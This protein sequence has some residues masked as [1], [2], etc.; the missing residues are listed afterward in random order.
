MN[1]FFALVHCDIVLNIIEA[2]T[3]SK[4]RKTY[5]K[6]VK[7]NQKK[8][9]KTNENIKK[10]RNRTQVIESSKHITQYSFLKVINWLSY[11]EL[12]E[13]GTFMDHYQSTMNNV[14]V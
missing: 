3:K 10:Q 8:K 4:M 6:N 11:K 13:V 2:T 7:K 1:V 14:C 9:N 5:V 12:V